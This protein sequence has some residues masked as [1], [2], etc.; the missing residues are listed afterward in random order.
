MANPIAVNFDSVKILIAFA[1]H[2]QKHGL[3][4]T[5]DLQVFIDEPERVT[6]LVKYIK[7][8]A[9]IWQ[10]ET[11]PDINWPAVYQ[12]LGMEA[13]YQEFVKTT[14]WSN[15][16]LWI[17]PAIN[18]ATCNKVVAAMKNDGVKFWPNKD[19]DASLSRNDRDPNKD[20]SYVVG[21]RR[22]IEADEENKNLSADI[23][24]EHNHKGITLLERLLLGAGYFWTTG[25]H[26][27]VKNI[28]LSTGS[29][30]LVGSVPSVC[31]FFSVYGEVF[32]SWYGPGIRH[33]SLRSRSAVPPPV[34]EQLA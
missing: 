21:F 12:K 16:S 18:G 9:P 30:D 31:F 20:G 29:R 14:N 3:E 13:E 11:L 24:A 6:R 19:L 26:L 25:Q 23:L 4:I 33:D 7:A 10:V 2:A 17:V 34:A 5:Y 22:T 1:E 8:G 27:D 15:P 32:V 28:T